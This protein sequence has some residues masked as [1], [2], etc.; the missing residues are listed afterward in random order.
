MTGASAAARWRAASARLSPRSADG[1]CGA[2]D[3]VQMIFA[4]VDACATPAR[5][6]SWHLPFASEARRPRRRRSPNAKNGLS[7]KNPYDR[8]QEYSG[9]HQDGPGEQER[10]RAHTPGRL[11]RDRVARRLVRFRRIV[12]IRVGLCG[13]GG[14]AVRLAYPLRIDPLRR[15]RGA[16]VRWRKARCRG[17]VGNDRRESGRP[18]IGVGVRPARHQ[19]AV[20]D[21]RRRRPVFR[22]GRCRLIGERLK[23]DCWHELI[24]TG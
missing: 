5:E 1:L 12:G 21:A 2:L 18:R 14:Y 22:P 6:K 16:T 9:N 24:G 19:G 3:F 7:G 8:V 13:R 15:P 4:S 11:D 20:L 23:P 17:G 10:Q